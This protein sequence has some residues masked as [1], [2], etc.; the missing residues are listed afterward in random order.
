MGG[1][2]DQ[3]DITIGGISL[4]I[5]EVVIGLTFLSL[6]TTAFKVGGRRATISTIGRRA[7]IDYKQP[8]SYIRYHQTY[9]GPVASYLILESVSVD[10]PAK[11]VDSYYEKRNYSMLCFGH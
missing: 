6:A 3:N 2:V 1:A 9:L 7:T 8:F 4:A 10:A 5:G 11:K